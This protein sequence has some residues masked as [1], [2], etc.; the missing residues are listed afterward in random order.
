MVFGYGARLLAELEVRGV[1][2]Q[3]LQD[4]PNRINDQPALQI[5]TMNMNTVL[6]LLLVDGI[7]YGIAGWYFQNCLPGKT[8]LR[9]ITVDRYTL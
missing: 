6:V 2:A 5:D 1:G 7:A 4:V 3:W 9:F 8:K